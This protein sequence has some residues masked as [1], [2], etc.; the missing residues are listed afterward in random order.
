MSPG[1]WAPHHRA[2]FDHLK[3]KEQMLQLDPIATVPIIIFTSLMLE[4]LGACT[5]LPVQTPGRDWH[6]YTRWLWRAY[7]LVTRVG[8]AAAWV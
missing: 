2:E 8:S 6:A 7:V 3:F 5:W 1:T 4:A